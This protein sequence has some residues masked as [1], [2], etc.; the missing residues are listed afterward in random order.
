MQNSVLY[1]IVIFFTL[2]A[3]SCTEIKNN[4]QSPDGKITV[5]FNF[6]EGIPEYSV[7][8]KNKIITDKSSLGLQLEGS[9]ING[10]FSLSG[11][12]S[13]EKD[14]VW[15]PV[16]GKTSEVKNRYNEWTIKLKEKRSPHKK[17]NITFRL[18]DDGIAFRYNIPKQQ[19]VDTFIIKKDLTTF[20]F[21]NDVTWWS[22][23]GENENLGPLPLDSFP[24]KTFLPFVGKLNDS[25]WIAIHEGA[26]YHY[27][28]FKLGKSGQP[29]TLNCQ[30]L[31]S[32]GK[33]GVP[34]SWRVMFIG[35]RPGKFLE[36][37]L[38]ENL[39]PPCQIKDPS[40]IKPGKSM[41]DW[42]VWGYKTSGGYEYGLNTVSHKRFV[43]FA[44]KHN[45]RYMLIDADWY[46]PEFDKNSDPTKAREGVDIENFMKYA[47]ERNVDVILYLNDV[48]AR[49]YGLDTILSR[50]RHW[51]VA[52]IK[53]GFMQ[54][55]GQEKVLH[56]REVVKACAKNK[57]LVNFHDYPIPPSGDT[58]TWPN[59]IAREYCHA[60][61]DAKRSYWPETAV[62]AA[63]INMITGP[64]DLDNGWF[65]LNNA[66]KRVRV[67]E[68]I[69]G[70]VAAEAAKILVYYSGLT[71]LPDAPE[72]Y[73]KKADLFGFIENL[74]D[75]YDEIKVLDGTPDSFITIARRKGDN[76][77]LG[78]LT[79][80]TG[81]Q[82][83][84]PLNFLNKNKKYKAVIYEDAPDSDYLKNKE[85]Y[86]IREENV[87]A[88][89]TM[90]IKLAPGGG[91]GIRFEEF[92]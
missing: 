3:Y 56:T 75:S 91:C 81:R 15:H 4:F 65:D 69:P 18:Y 28:P 25:L 78:S 35:K 82:L 23:N 73:E 2:T 54:G 90:H 37:N 43:D 49:K 58:R 67:F 12:S 51:G 14:T 45:I 60:Q 38:L 64:L 63:F 50:F 59:L 79:N 53:Y 24:Q 6:N 41:W 44:S 89:D 87:E 52:G 19:G 86:N 13:T 31:P 34:T 9:E 47:H 57:L 8:Y 7:L 32:A 17:I 1:F 10:P 84:I 62:S 40:W 26:I 55:E 76:W 68:P 48:G 66:D 36:S 27:S 20:H 42:R 88:G 70:T 83:D 30:M 39:N 29:R 21:T 16:I 61:A 46:G 92:N 72:E 5:K 74:P 11:I 33:A 80:R 85:A 22:A 77:Y 71:V